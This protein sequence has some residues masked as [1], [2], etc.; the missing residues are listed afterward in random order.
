MLAA[1]PLTPGHRLKLR[2]PGNPKLQVIGPSRA[3]E[4]C[5]GLDEPFGRAYGGAAQDPLNARV[6]VG[7]MQA[8]V[9]AGAR[10]GALQPCVG[11]ECGEGRATRRERQ[12]ECTPPQEQ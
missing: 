11:A 4:A 7:L 9:A 2:Q 1:R 5:A 8:L 3:R 12:A 6:A 10:A